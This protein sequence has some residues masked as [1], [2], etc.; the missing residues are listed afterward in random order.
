MLTL[1]TLRFVMYLPF[2]RISD[3]LQVTIFSVHIK[4]CILNCIQFCNIFNLPF[5]RFHD[6]IK[7]NYYFNLYCFLNLRL[8]KALNRGQKF[9]IIFVKN[10][11]FPPNFC[12]GLIFYRFQTHCNKKK[13]KIVGGGRIEKVPC[14]L[15]TPLSIGPRKN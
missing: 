11:F 1:L 12:G 6:K 14:F 13:W 10:K 9:I 5:L 2:C 8:S 15:R 7:N 3:S 4:T